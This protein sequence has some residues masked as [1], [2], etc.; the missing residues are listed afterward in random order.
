MQTWRRLLTQDDLAQTLKTHFIF[1]PE[2]VLLLSQESAN[3]NERRVVV[4]A[5]FKRKDHMVLLYRAHT[6]KVTADRITA[7]IQTDKQPEEHIE[8]NASQH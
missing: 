8:N 2:I 1:N 3:V 5:F 6:G 4:Q 7:F